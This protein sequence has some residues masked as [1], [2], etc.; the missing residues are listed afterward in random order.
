[1]FTAGSSCFLTLVYVRM[2]LSG[3][4]CAR[5]SLRSVQPVSSRFAGAAAS[6]MDQLGKN[7]REVAEWV[8]DRPLHCP[9]SG[10]SV[11]R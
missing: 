4:M 5:S 6:E 11:D 8:P 2:Y 10:R 9:G 7:E 1:M 3:N